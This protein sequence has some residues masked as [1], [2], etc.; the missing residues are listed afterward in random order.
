MAAI[1][2]AATS[3]VDR[4]RMFA[5]SPLSGSPSAPSLTHAPPHISISPDDS[6]RSAVSA[7]LAA[8][9]GAGANRGSSMGEGAC[10]SA[11]AG[12]GS[13]PPMS[14]AMPATPTA[15]A[16][17]APAIARRTPVDLR[18]GSGS[19]LDIFDRHALAW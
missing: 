11:V 6:G 2:L 14:Q 19:M 13:S 18:S 16:V 7:A 12:C 10:A 17:T 1:A 3:F 5:N 8:A 9:T 15:P 4:L